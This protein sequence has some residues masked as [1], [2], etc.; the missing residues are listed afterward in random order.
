MCNRLRWSSWHVHVCCLIGLCAGPFAWGAAGV[1][2]DR[3][4]PHWFA[5]NSRFWYRNELPG[6]ASEFVVVD[7]EK[8]IRDAAFDHERVATSLGTALS[9]AVTADHLPI[10]QLDFE[11]ADGGVMLTV[12]GKQWRLD[13]K[14]Y[15][16]TPT[17]TAGG[18]AVTGDKPHASVAGGAATTLTLI[19]HT[20]AAVRVVWVDTAGKHQRYGNI[21]AG[22]SSELATFAGHVWLVTDDKGQ[23]LKV[24]EAGP[25][26]TTATIEGT[27]RTAPPP[28]RRGPAAVAAQR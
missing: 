17:G 7:A 20:A 14:S 1:Y 3:V 23:V 28:Q 19:N 6:N 24:V 11:A 27:Q 2:R 13:P 4:E 9:R 21:D 22:G 5:E 12:A 16:I 8:G 10:D 18:S 26:A 25:R 15:A